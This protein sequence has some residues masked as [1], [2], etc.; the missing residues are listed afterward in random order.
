MDACLKAHNAKRAL[1]K[2]TPALKWNSKLARHAKKW[3]KHLA[4]TGNIEHEDNTGEGENIYWASGSTARTC[5]DA[6]EAW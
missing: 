4:A 5:A 1:H 3:A 6:V 2:D